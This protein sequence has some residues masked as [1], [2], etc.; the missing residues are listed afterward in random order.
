[1]LNLPEKLNEECRRLQDAVASVAGVEPAALSEGTLLAQL[2]LASAE[3]VRLCV[4]CA[5]AISSLLSTREALRPL[6]ADAPAA[7]P[8]FTTRVMAAIKAKENELEERREGV[9]IS[10]LRQ[11]PRLAAFC[12]L[13]LV[14]GGGWVLQL[15]QSDP[16]RLDEGKTVE[17]VFDT[18]AQ[19]S[20]FNDDVL[21]PAHEAHR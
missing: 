18:N 11:A 20:P 7:G 17:T 12:T 2:P 15:R 14:I 19:S 1:M 4:T 13:L 3:H 8:W 16:V 9:W 10:V 5:E 6:I 21:L